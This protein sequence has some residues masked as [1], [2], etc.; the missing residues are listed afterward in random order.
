MTV[1]TIKKNAVWEIYADGKYIATADNEEDTKILLE[2]I[3]AVEKSNEILR[4]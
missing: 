3:D 1:S 4:V 2:S